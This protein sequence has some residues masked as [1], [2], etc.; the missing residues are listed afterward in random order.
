[1]KN[2][3]EKGAIMVE[4]LAV[5][6]LIGVMGP[7]LYNQVVA[8]NQEISNVNIA[9]EMRAIKEAMSAVIAADGAFLGEACTEAGDAPTRCVNSADDFRANVES[10][11]PVGMEGMVDSGDY[12]VKLYGYRATVSSGDERTFVFGVVS[13]AN[14]PTVWNFKRAAR[15]ASLIGADGGVREPGGVDLIGTNGTWQL[16]GIGADFTCNLDNE[17]NVVVATTA[18]DTFDPDLGITDPYAVA[19]PDSM[20]FERLHAW[21][22]FSVGHATDGQQGNCIDLRSRELEEDGSSSTIT[23]QRDIIS[24]VGTDACDPLFWVGTKGGETDKSVAGQVYI[25]N[26]LYIGRDNT[27]N[28]HAVAIETHE[29]SAGGDTANKQRRIAVYDI[30]GKETLTIDALG[31]IIAKQ[32]SDGTEVFAKTADG[33]KV[34]Y[35]V[36]PANTSVLNDVRLTSRGGARLSDILPTYINKGMS[37]ITSSGTTH[38]VTAKIKKPGCPNGYAAAIIVTPMKWG[39]SQVE[40][41]TVPEQTIVAMHSLTAPAGGGKVSGNINAKIPSQTLQK[42]TEYVTSRNHLAIEIDGT[43]EN[44]DKESDGKLYDNYYK[45]PTG[46]VWTVNIG[47]KMTPTSTTWETVNVK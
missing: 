24:N 7:M 22:Y 26:N 12:D 38:P 20:G 40:S 5:L 18:L 1:M 44:N 9:A 43:D 45:N 36:D 13:Y 4:V 47:Y 42:G 34:R 6:A 33:E 28:K 31:R 2:K 41:I 30:D 23:A 21:N 19:V 16:K 32:Y 17:E 10:F 11:L 35:G 8:R 37:N 27:G 39:Q 29:S 3:Q 15:V 25:K 46:D 14:P